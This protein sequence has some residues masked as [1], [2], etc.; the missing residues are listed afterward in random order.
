MNKGMMKSKNKIMLITLGCIGAV[1]LIIIL[2]GAMN[3]GRESLPS[4]DTITVTKGDVTQEVDASGSVESEQK[5]TFFSPING[6]VQTMS[7]GTGDTVEEGQA[8]I[9]FNLESLESENQKAELNVRSGQLEM[10]DAQQQ[11]ADAASRQAQAQARIPEL[12]A[13]AL[14]AVLQPPADQLLGGGLDLLFHDLGADVFL[15]DLLDALSP[16][17]GA[18]TPEHPGPV[19][20]AADISDGRVVIS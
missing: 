8:I 6:E 14:R 4:V 7:A 10:Q 17:H 11:A 12:E 2:I 19:P 20:Y 18:G 16:P 15:F 1:F 13:Q 9:G 3:P 5:K